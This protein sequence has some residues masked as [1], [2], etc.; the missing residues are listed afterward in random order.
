MASRRSVLVNPLGYVSEGMRLALTLSMPH[1]NVP[2]MLAALL[3]T[4]V[5]FWRSGC[6]LR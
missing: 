3:A 6:T 4:A 2:V 5:L 1:M